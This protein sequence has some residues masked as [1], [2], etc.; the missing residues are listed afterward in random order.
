[1]KEYRELRC[2]DNT[3]KNP[4][5]LADE[6]NKLSREGWQ[7]EAFIY[8]VGGADGVYYRTLVSREME[9]PVKIGSLSESR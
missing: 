3:T 5:L 2:Y 4:N 6:V 8:C 9:E 7:F 1:M